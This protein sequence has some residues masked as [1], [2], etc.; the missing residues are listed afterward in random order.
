MGR[1]RKHRGFMPHIAPVAIEA[2]DLPQIE[3]TFTLDRQIA[4]ARAS[5]GEAR[6]AELNREWQ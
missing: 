4:A 6:W 2:N 1:R 5:M 3:P